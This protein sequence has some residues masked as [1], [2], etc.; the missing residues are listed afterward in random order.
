MR[1]VGHWPVLLVAPSDGRH[2]SLVSLTLRRSSTTLEK[3][4]EIRTLETKPTTVAQLSSRHYTFA[5]PVTE[6]LW[7]YP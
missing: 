1:V 2:Q 5:S 6:C 3:K 4:V 7:V